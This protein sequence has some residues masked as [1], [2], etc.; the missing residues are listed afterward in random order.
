MSSRYSCRWFSRNIVLIFFF[1]FFPLIRC[2]DDQTCL[3]QLI[4]HA[5]AQGKPKAEYAEIWIT[6]RYFPPAVFAAT[7]LGV[8]EKWEQDLW[9]QQKSC[10]LP[11]K[12]LS[13]PSA[14]KPE[15]RPHHS[16]APHCW[17][18]ISSNKNLI[19]ILKICDWRH[20]YWCCSVNFYCLGLHDYATVDTA[21]CLF[22]LE[23]YITEVNPRHL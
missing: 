17:M 15:L 10:L 22:P 9:S 11:R 14:S 18:K 12:E 4:T 7:S 6:H 20:R 23:P 1:I 13:V 5:E 19:D 8:C 3:M 2:S 21:P 16:T